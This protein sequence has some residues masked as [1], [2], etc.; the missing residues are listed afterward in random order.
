[1]PVKMLTDYKNIFLSDVNKEILQQINQNT[2]MFNSVQ[3]VL[4]SQEAVPKG[5]DLELLDDQKNFMNMLMQTYI[6]QVRTEPRRY[7]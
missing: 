1:M 3:N 7:V 6:E 4:T 2:Q 5:L